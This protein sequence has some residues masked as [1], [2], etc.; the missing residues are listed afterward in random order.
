MPAASSCVLFVSRTACRKEAGSS[1]HCPDE[2]LRAGQEVGRVAAGLHD[3]S[4]SIDELTERRP[5]G[6]VSAEGNQVMTFPESTY[7]IFQVY[8][9]PSHRQTECVALQDEREQ[10]STPKEARCSEQDRIN[11]QSGKCSISV[12]VWSSTRPFHR[13]CVTPSTPFA[14]RDRLI[15]GGASGSCVLRRHRRLSRSAAVSGASR[16]HE[17]G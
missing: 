10:R 13:T 14:S 1:A 15:R 6:P 2:Q 5:T 4:S 3:Y 9:R 17:S 7:D 12:T 8:A 16:R 11:S